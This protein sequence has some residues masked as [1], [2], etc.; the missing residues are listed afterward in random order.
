MNLLKFLSFTVLLTILFACSS[1]SDPDSKKNPLDRFDINYDGKSLVLSNL[2]ASTDGNYFLITGSKY[3][4]K[5][6]DGYPLTNSLSLF[7]HKDGT[8]INASMYD[9][10][11]KNYLS[12][13]FYFSK[14]SFKFQIENIDEVNKRINVNFEG[15]LYER[16]IVGAQEEVNGSISIVYKDSNPSGTNKENFG[17]TM[18][19]NDQNWRG[20]CTT[21][22]LS[23]G[24]ITHVLNIKGDSQYSI[25]IVVPKEN[26][27][28]GTYTFSK[29]SD[30]YKDYTVNFFRYYANSGLNEFISSG[31][32]TITEI[33]K[34]RNIIGTFSLTATNPI[35]NETVSVTEG[36][37]K[38]ELDL[39]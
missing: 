27:K 26:L 20:L 31:K 6:A 21:S 8:L 12:S 19:V 14:D 34:G 10:S 28:I 3:G 18:K 24:E 23:S 1:D 30:V 2:Y 11:I 15:T 32:L 17:T 9:I 25:N 16:Y 5:E 13:S 37:F 33:E 38:E 35:T 7:F 22:T 39:F 29:N 4:K 36:N